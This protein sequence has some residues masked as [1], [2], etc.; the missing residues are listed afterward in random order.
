MFRFKKNNQ[1][2]A[3]SRRF[4]GAGN[5]NQLR[6]GS[7]QYGSYSSSGY[8]CDNGISLGILITAALGIAIMFYTLYTKIT[9]GRRRKKRSDVEENMDL[10]LQDVD[11]L[12]FAISHITDFLYSGQYINILI[13]TRVELILREIVSLGSKKLLQSGLQLISLGLIAILLN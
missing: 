1:A 7:Q 10:V 13:S 9:M 5:N 2:A 11:P 4:G 12:Q 8:G 6:S 3:I